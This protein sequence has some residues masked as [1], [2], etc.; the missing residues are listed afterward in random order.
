MKNTTV[1]IS[2][3]FSICLLAAFFFIS[4]KNIP[5]KAPSPTP[6]IIDP[7]PVELGKVQWLRNMDEARE[8]AQAEQKPILILFQ[9][10]PGCST[11]RRY[12]NGALS[13]PLIVEAIESEFVPLAIFN[14]KKG[15]D[16]EVLEYFGEP[17]WNNPVV[18]MVNADRQDVVPRLGGDYSEHGLV[19]SMLLALRANNRAAPRYLQILAEEMQA[20]SI[21]TETAT[22][23][24][25]CF[26]TG[27]K[28]LAKVPG[29]VA[30]EAG[31]MGGREVVRVEYNPLLTTYEGLVSEAKKSNCASH[32]FTEGEGQAEAAALVVGTSATSPAGK[33]RVDSEPKYYLSRTI[34]QYVPMT[35]LQSAR[36]NSL[37]GQRKL[38][39]EVLSPRQNEWA[40]FMAGHPDLKWENAIGV[41]IGAAWEAAEKIRRTAR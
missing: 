41:E 26:W 21:G 34:Y 3:A 4:S 9:E 12:G 15:A 13:H 6:Q 25:Y 23:S 30:T 39:T 2:L 36:A 16:A 8:R 37:V 7:Q 19:N 10:V 22:L 29:V 40:D 1:Q 17:S 5:P 24:M 20:K 38:P 32:V 31:W 27:E 11:C 14:N 35:P 18:R 28:E 33:Y